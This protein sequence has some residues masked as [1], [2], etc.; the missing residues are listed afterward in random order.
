[1]NDATEVAEPYVYERGNPRRR[2]NLDRI[3]WI[4]GLMPAGWR[5]TRTT[6][7]CMAPSPRGPFLTKLG[8]LSRRSFRKKVA[9]SGRGYAVLGQLKVAGMAGRRSW[10]LVV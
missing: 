6:S 2:C 3:P 8:A 9:T 4:G 5:L 7:V 10:I 1:M